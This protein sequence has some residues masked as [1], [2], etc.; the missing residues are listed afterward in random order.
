MLRMLCLKLGIFLYFFIK[1]TFHSS[2]SGKEEQAF[3]INE[4]ITSLLSIFLFIL[5]DEDYLCS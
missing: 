5:L 4:C 3:D 2:I 1:L